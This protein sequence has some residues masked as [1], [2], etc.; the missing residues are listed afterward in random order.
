MEEPAAAE[1]GEAR[2]CVFAVWLHG[3]G[4]C[5]RANK[6]IA[7]HFAAAAFASTRWAFPTATTSPDACTPIS[8][9]LASP[10]HSCMI[11]WVVK[12]IVFSLDYY[13]I[14]LAEYKIKKNGEARSYSSRQFPR[15][16]AHRVGDPII[17]SLVDAQPNRRR[18]NEPSGQ[19]PLPNPK[20]FAFAADSPTNRTPPSSG[21]RRLPRRAASCCGCTAP[22]GRATRAEPRSRPT[23]PPRRSRPPSA[24]PSPPRPPLPSPATV[25]AFSQ[26]PC[27][28]E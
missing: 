25:R 12:A 13:V 5:G 11:V 15:H 14:L 10:L 20:R 22:A 16:T 6:V 27:Q 4:N 18:Q 19:R 17:G 26:A 3:L 24:S 2:S 21:W 8:S 9:A 28:S 23:S 1:G 7:D